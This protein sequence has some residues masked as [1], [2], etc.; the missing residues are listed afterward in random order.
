MA[1]NFQWEAALPC[2]KSNFGNV[3]MA[4]WPLAN[5]GAL[6]KLEELQ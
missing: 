5:C 4:A 6:S 2:R 1:L 3:S